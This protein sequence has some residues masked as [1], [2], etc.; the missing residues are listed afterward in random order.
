MAYFH[1]KWARNRGG[2]KRRSMLRIVGETWEEMLSLARTYPEQTVINVPP[3]GV[4][5]YKSRSLPMVWIDEDASKVLE[6]IGSVEVSDDHILVLTW[7]IRQEIYW[8]YQGHDQDRFF[9]RGIR[10]SLG[11]LLKKGL[12]VDSP[13]QVS[14]Q[15]I[16]R[17]HV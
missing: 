9:V 4:D 3:R 11:E 6:L 8:K 5:S 14:L 16:G 15:K 10:G 13:S 1:A 2:V 7:M 12:W 17:A